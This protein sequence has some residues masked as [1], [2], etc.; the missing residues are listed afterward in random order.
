M[1]IFYTLFLISWFSFG[2]NPQAKPPDLPDLQPVNIT[3][4]QEGKPLIGADV[5]LM[6]DQTNEKWSA[7]GVTDTSGI[8]VPCTQGKYRGVPVGKFKICVSKT[9][10]ESTVGRNESYSGT[11]PKSY[12]LVEEQY[13]NP[14]TSPLE[15]E[16]VTGKNV[17][18]FD[19][20][21]VVRIPIL[22]S[23]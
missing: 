13:A 18:K 16:I 5:V 23:P 19:V 12:R 9:E 14:I 2:C 3:I 10:T 7:G 21:K 8:V 11:P 17:G 1:R 6:P 4:T 15:I 20:G 22:N